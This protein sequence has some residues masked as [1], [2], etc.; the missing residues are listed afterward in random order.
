[1]TNPPS[2]GA[3]ALEQRHAADN[4][5]LFRLLCPFPSGTHAVS[6]A[7]GESAANVFILLMHI[8]PKELN[9][10]EESFEWVALASS[11]RQERG[12]IKEKY[13]VMLVTKRQTLC[14]TFILNKYYP[15]CL[16]IAKVYHGK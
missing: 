2:Q 9:Y 13:M 14:I 15:F 12:E 6:T 1:M 7:E 10:R 16:K 11:T 3:L 8:L 5:Q 4:C